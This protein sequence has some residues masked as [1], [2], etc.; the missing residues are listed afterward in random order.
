MPSESSA[1]QSKRRTV[2]EMMPHEIPWSWRALA[3]L[4]LAIVGIVVT[5]E[6]AVM[7]RRPTELAEPARIDLNFS[8]QELLESLPSIGPALAQAIIAA[9]PFASAEELTRVRGVGLKL[10]EKLRPLIQAAPGRRTA[11]TR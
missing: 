3:I 11:D 7:H 8:S 6:S 4:V 10:L 1:R 5:D 9:R 2:A